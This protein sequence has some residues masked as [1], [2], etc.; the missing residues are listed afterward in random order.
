M[1]ILITYYLFLFIAGLLILREATYKKYKIHLLSIA[2]VLIFQLINYLVHDVLDPFIIIAVL[3]QYLI[4][5][6][7]LY[8]AVFAKALILKWRE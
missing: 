5:L 1:K 8:L 4:G 2:S 7:V 6:I 3:V